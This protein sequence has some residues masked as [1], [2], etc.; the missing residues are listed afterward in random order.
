MNIIFFMHQCVNENICNFAIFGP[1]CMKFSPNC[2]AKELGILFTILGSFSS[3]LDWERADRP[4]KI[5]D[6][7]HL[8]S[9]MTFV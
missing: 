7:R 5:D 2:R 4:R 3:F 8:T 6:M 9:A 1:I